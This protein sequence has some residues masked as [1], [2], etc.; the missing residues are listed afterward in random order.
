V[1]P[2]LKDPNRSAAKLTPNV[3]A[4]VVGPLLVVLAAVFSGG[5]LYTRGNWSWQ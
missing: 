5:V 2:L 1:C 3:I 4:L